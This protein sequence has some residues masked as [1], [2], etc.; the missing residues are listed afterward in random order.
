MDA[1][2]DALANWNGELMPLTEVKVSVLDRAFLFG[3]SLY[4][5]IRIYAGQP[6]RL[7]LHLDRLFTGLQALKLAFPIDTVRQRLSQTIKESNLK[8]AIAYIQVTRGV[9]QRHHYYPE[10]AR[11]NCL[12]YV[13]TFADTFKQ[14]RAEGGKAITYPDIRWAHNEWKT[15]SL[16][17]N[18]MAAEAAK[19]KGCVEAI[20]V[21]NEDAITEGSHSSVFAVRD[22]VVLAAGKQTTVLPGITKGLINELCHK[23]HI[24]TEERTLYLSDLPTLDELFITST[25]EEIMPILQLD[26]MKVGKGAVGYVTKQLQKAF[27]NEIKHWLAL[28]GS[29]E[30]K[31]HR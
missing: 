10:H 14:L 17:A 19:Q 20:L 1:L 31:L 23:N 15:N 21:N 12:I 29:S 18:C 28:N 25:P 4:E 16:A 5:V 2:D 7:E 9:A 24:A 30:T 22:G 8:E 11:P 26:N 6:F 27:K 13:E 3:D